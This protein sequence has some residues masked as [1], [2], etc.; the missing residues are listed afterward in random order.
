MISPQ[1][2]IKHSCN[3]LKLFNLRQLDWV[4]AICERLA[5]LTN[6]NFFGMLFIES[7]YEI[8]KN[9]SFAHECF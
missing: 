3:M 1:T 4:Y 6:F 2:L 5:P 9:F 7:F 8:R